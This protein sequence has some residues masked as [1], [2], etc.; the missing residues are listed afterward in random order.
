MIRRAWVAAG[1][2][3]VGAVLMA[4]GVGWRLARAAPPAAAPPCSVAALSAL[5]KGAATIASATTAQAGGATYCK[6]EGSVAT[7]GD[8]APPGTARFELNLPAA[9]N[10]KVIFVGGGGFDGEVPP[11]PA[12]EVARGYATLGTDSGHVG[13]RGYVDAG[14][15]IGWVRTAS[16]E[17]DAAR[18]ADYAIR[19]RHA[20]DIKVRPI[21]S[22]YYRGAKVE[23]AYF[24]GCSGGGR[25]ALIEAQRHPEAFDGFIAG[26]PWVNARS[27]LLAARN[28][29]VLLDAPIPYAK[30]AAIDAAVRQEC[31]KADGVADGLIQNP[32]ACR[33]DP[34]TLVKAGVLTAAQADALERYLT[35]VR[36]SDG[37]F[38]TYGGSVAGIGDLSGVLPGI[39]GG[40]TG[41]SV[42]QTD[43]PAPAPEAAQPWGS[44]GK[45]TVGWMLSY[46]V[47]AGLAFND[48]DLDIVGQG[49]LDLTGGVRP[50]AV[51]MVDQQLSPMVVDPSAM[52]A[53][54]KKK[55][56]L[57]IYQGYADAILD[58]FSTIAVYRRIAAAGGGLSKASASARLFM[59]PDMQ[60]CAGGTGPNAF[61]PLAAME[62][63]VERGVAP[64]AIIASKFEGGDPT[65]RVLR[66]M[67]LCPY[68]QMA[69]Y[70]GH[71]DVNQASSWRCPAG[72]KGL[73]EL[74]PAGRKA[75]A[76]KDIVPPE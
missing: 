35:A 52:A 61:D 11:T 23:R 71:G 63:W 26:D 41:L 56:K 17:R 72:D 42:Y 12:S 58:P 28:F 47:L 39:A 13:G 73:L 51:A 64:A 76:A 24:M 44:L 54:F 45:G 20:V 38:V 36:D 55:R 10:R 9:W 2:L 67:P 27:G 69:R 66:T 37:R 40:L 74:G 7:L 62:A 21:V 14:L 53:M 75:G 34:R 22:R 16:G 68:P 65:K 33:F 46:G 8:G 19:A 4:A 18:L 30:F 43:P 31:D 60:H 49:V 6:V 59:V 50:G 70:D 48:P 25:E 5:A 29:R 3:A 57:I 1:A 15:D 32:A